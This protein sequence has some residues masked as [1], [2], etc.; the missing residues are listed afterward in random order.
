MFAAAK[1]KTFESYFP[2]CE[3]E[4]RKARHAN[5]RKLINACDAL[6]AF[7][8]GH[9]EETKRLIDMAKNDH[10]CV[11]IIYINRL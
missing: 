2:D 9:H 4:V 1:N 5:N 6:I 10:K 11:V 7:Y 8:D 3:K